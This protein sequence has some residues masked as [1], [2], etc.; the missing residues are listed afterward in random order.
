MKPKEGRNDKVA[1]LLDI[2]NPNEPFV[3]VDIII[4]TS[5]ILNNLISNA[6]KFSNIG[7]AVEVLVFETESNVKICVKD[8][9]I[10]IPENVLSKIFYFSAVTT[11]QGTH[12]EKG[13]GFGMPIV[14]SF[15]QKFNGKINIETSMEEKSYARVTIELPR[16]S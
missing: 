9:D 7:E 16:V 8:N 10:G 1:S 12:G 14:S 2:I 3:I 11:C 5:Q 6:I 13:T 4:F 15:L